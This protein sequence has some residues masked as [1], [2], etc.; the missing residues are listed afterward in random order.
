M[1][2]SAVT[3]GYTVYM[4]LLGRE[5]DEDEDEDA[6]QGLLLDPVLLLLSG[7]VFV[8]AR[9]RASFSTPKQLLV[10]YCIQ[11]RYFLYEEPQFGSMLC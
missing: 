3:V 4:D 5:E 9:V 6:M 1:Q 11:Y 2:W 7:I 8:V 10:Q